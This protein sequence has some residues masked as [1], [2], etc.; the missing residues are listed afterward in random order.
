MPH[1]LKPI[2]RCCVADGVMTKRDIVLFK[3]IYLCE[4]HRRLW[5]AAD[6]GLRRHEER[7]VEVS[8]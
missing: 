2:E 8:Q 3:R 7:R 4:S 5:D 1:D 6:A